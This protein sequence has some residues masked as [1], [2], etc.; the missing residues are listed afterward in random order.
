MLFDQLNTSTDSG[1]CVKNVTL[2]L[3]LTHVTNV[4]PQDTLKPLF[5]LCFVLENNLQT[6]TDLKAEKMSRPPKEGPDVVVLAKGLC[7]SVLTL[8]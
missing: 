6:C 8:L 2:C 4:S 7:G 1:S 3:C 5:L